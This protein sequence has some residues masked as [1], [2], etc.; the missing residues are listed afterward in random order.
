MSLCEPWGRRRSTYACL[1]TL[2]LFRTTINDRVGKLEALLWGLFFC[3]FPEEKKIIFDFCFF[4]LSPEEKK[5][6]SIFSLPHPK[7]LMAKLSVLYVQKISCIIYR[8][9][10]LLTNHSCYKGTNREYLAMQICE[11]H[12]TYTRGGAIYCSFFIGLN[13]MWCHI[14]TSLSILRLQHKF[15]ATGQS[16]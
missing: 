14:I 8:F 13:Y 3:S 1:R 5:S 2:Y 15:I 11:S 16:K 4:V 7:P 9:V 10:Q 6:F 12:G